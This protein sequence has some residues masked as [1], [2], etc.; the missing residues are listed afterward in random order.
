MQANCSDYDNDVVAWSAE[1]A[2]LLRARQFDAIDIEH[3]AEEIEDVG[4]SEQRE[5]A[6]RLAV[7]L[8]HLIK[9]HH[10]PECRGKSRQLTIRNQRRGI[11]LRLRR[12]PSLKPMLRDPEW[13]QELWADAAAAA[14]AEA[15]ISELPY[16]CPWDM[17]QVLASNWLPSLDLRP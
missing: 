14:S 1:Q 13:Q 12:T 2:R 3:V 4:K 8:A 10:Q 15:G 11:E 9:W 16:Q 7:L 17:D 6:S 5:L